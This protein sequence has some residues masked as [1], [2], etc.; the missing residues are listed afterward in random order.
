MKLHTHMHITIYIGK[1]LLCKCHCVP[2][3]YNTT[4]VQNYHTHKVGY[5]SDFHLLFSISST[6]GC[7]TLSYDGKR[8]S[9]GRSWNN[10]DKT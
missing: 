2:V 5:H 10:V 1:N 9:L 4:T 6:F 7:N 8:Y 3:T